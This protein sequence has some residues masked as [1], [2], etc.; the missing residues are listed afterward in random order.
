MYAKV[1]KNYEADM[2]DII[3]E[4]RAALALAGKEHRSPR[5]YQA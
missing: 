2:L 1:R 3:R 5:R 4:A